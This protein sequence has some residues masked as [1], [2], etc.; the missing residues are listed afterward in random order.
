MAA[1]GGRSLHTELTHLERDLVRAQ[2]QTIVGLRNDG[3]LS[4]EAA[5]KILRELDLNEITLH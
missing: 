5:R 4:H 3:T 1:N 2:R